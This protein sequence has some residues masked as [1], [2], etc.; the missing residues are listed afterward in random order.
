MLEK[1]VYPNTWEIPVESSGGSSYFV[2]LMLFCFDFSKKF[3]PETI[4]T[5]VPPTALG[6]KK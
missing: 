1:L 4:N 2:S 3:W 5:V 6:F